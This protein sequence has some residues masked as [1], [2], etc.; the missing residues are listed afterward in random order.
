MMI[1]ALLILAVAVVA[2]LAALD[3][4][5]IVNKSSPEEEREENWDWKPR[6][7]PSVERYV[8]PKR[9]DRLP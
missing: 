2:L 3:Y 5:H 9:E 6:W 7:K 8:G 4:R 1:F